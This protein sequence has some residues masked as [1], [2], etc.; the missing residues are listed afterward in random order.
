MGIVP[1][2]KITMDGINATLITEGGVE[3]GG[4][5]LTAKKTE[6]K[7]LGENEIRALVERWWFWNGMRMVLP[8]VGT[9]MGFWIALK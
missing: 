5:L 6:A 2:T 9:A 8:L 7:G 4:N 1:F 3:G